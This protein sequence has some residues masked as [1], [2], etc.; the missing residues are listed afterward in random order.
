[1]KCSGVFA[2][3]RIRGISLVFRECLRISS[4]YSRKLREY[5]NVNQFLPN[6][7]VL[8]RVI[9]QFLPNNA[10]TQKWTSF[11]STSRK[12]LGP[13]LIF[14]IRGRPAFDLP[15]FRSCGK[16]IFENVA[17]AFWVM[18]QTHFGSRRG[19]EAVRSI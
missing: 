13:H 11:S 19:Y 6:V 7:C 4:R 12:F 1:M 16:R 14:Q 15:H 3:L 9:R 18:W 10:N 8:I 17:N 5:R 2:E